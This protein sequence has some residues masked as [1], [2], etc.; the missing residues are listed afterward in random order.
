MPM[1]N[2]VQ[3]ISTSLL[4]SRWFKT[5]RLEFGHKKLKAIGCM[6]LGK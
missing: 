2:V 1:K 6:C 5:E 3:Y 4:N